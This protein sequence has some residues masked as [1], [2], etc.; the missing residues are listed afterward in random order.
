MCPDQLIQLVQ[1]TAGQFMLQTGRQRWVIAIK[2][3]I[4]LPNTS[5]IIS[6]CVI[7]IIN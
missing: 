7:G 1:A 2:T 4:Q 3:N 6:N 5:P